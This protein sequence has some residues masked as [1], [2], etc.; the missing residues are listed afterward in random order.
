MA[1]WIIDFIEQY[2]YLGIAALMALEN[3]FPPLPSELIMPF[4]G[5]S[6]AQGS[7]SFAGVVAAGT[8]GSLIGTLPWYAAGRWASQQ[9]LERWVERH[10]RWFTLT[11]QQLDHARHWFERHGTRAVLLGRMVPAVRTVISV[12]A[13]VTGMAL[14]RFLLWSAIGSALWSGLLALLGRALGTRYEAVEQWMN[15]V[16]TLI[17]VAVVGIYLYRVITFRKSTRQD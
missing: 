7:L 13:G 17:I 3:I 6:T 15:P 9:R 10:G 1:Q 14:W 16:T 8:A 4:A 5:F 11:Q 2:G 12:P